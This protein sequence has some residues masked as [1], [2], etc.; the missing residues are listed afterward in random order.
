VHIRVENGEVTQTGGVVRIQHGAPAPETQS[1]LQG[2]PGLTRVGN[3]FH[4]FEGGEVKTS[5]VVRYQAG[6]E[7]ASRPGVMGTARREGGVLTVELEPGNPASR[8]D[9]AA[10][11]SEHLVRETIPGFYEDLAPVAAPDQPTAPKQ[12]PNEEAFFSDPE[13]T[14]IWSEA[15]A[16]LEQGSYDQ[17]VAGTV[18]AVAAGQDSFE[19]V[20]RSLAQANG[21]EVHEAH[22]LVATGFEWHKRT[23]TDRLAKE[24]LVTHESAERFYEALKGHPRLER[25]L[26]E[27]ALEGKSSEF[28]ALA[29][30]WKRSEGG[31]AQETMKDQLSRQGFQTS[32]DTN[33]G[34]LMVKRGSGPWLP[35]SR[36]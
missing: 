33:N 36:L 18:A 21:L 6:A 17:A 4:R 29:L 28:R 8:T 14:Q 7:T 20:A 2:H 27:V 1:P 5:G 9:I 11:I 16:P 24:G 13:E 30:E 10:A 12:A 23:L 35:L 22:E 34:E 26:Q 15:I 3:Q 32:I 19:S 31:R 25:A